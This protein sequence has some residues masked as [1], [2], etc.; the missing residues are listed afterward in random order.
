MMIYYVVGKKVPKPG[1][2][3]LMKWCGCLTCFTTLESARNAIKMF[4]YGERK[5]NYAIYSIE[6]GEPMQINEG[7]AESNDGTNEGEHV[8]GVQLAQSVRDEPK[9]G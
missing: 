1:F 2:V 7:V 4:V 8:E 6:V 5:G 3:D 9:G